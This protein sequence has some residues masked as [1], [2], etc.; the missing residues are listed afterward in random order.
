MRAR[1]RTLRSTGGIFL[2]LAHGLLVEFPA[3]EESQGRRQAIEPPAD[4]PPRRHDDDRPILLDRAQ[5]LFREVLRRH[6][7]ETFPVPA[8]EFR[9]RG[10]ERLAVFPSLLQG[11]RPDYSRAENA[12]PYAGR[13]GKRAIEL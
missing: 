8:L 9:W 2:Q 5:S 7:M 4:L 12:D 11:R 10:R 1:L 13:G 3:D 6:G